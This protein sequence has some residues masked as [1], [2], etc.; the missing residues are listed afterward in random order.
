M[1][2]KTEWG[3]KINVLPQSH[4]VHNVVGYFME[5]FTYVANQSRN[6]FLNQYNVISSVPNPSEFPDIN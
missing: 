4:R 6:V 3:Q 2:K 5:P 1:K